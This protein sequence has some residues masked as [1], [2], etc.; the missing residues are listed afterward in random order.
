MSIL[1]IACLAVS[2]WTVTHY[3]ENTIRPLQEQARRAHIEGE[4]KA[5][6]SLLKRKRYDTAAQE[7]RFILDAYDNELLKQD[8]GHKG[9]ISAFLDSI[10]YDNPSPI[11]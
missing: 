5:A 1:I 10:Q 7:Y 6:D 4:I 11:P 3:F 9:C 2:L 8:K